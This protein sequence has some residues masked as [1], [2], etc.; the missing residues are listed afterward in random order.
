MNHQD[1][2]IIYTM[3][4]LL[5]PRTCLKRSSG[6]I[7]R[8]I[9]SYRQ[10]ASKSG[11]EKASDDKDDKK[12]DKK[13]VDKKESSLASQ[14][15]HHDLENFSPDKSS[16]VSA[17][18]GGLPGT[19]PGLLKYINHPKVMYDP[20]KNREETSY[21]FHAPKNP[22][23]RYREKMKERARGKSKLR[24]L[25]PSL[26]AASVFLWGV[27]TY[28]YFTREKDKT[29]D[30]DNALLKPS[31][32]LPYVVSF[33]YKIDDDHYL[34]ELTRK[35][36]ARKLLHTSHLFNGSRIWSIE[37]AK[38]DI[39]IVRNYTPLPLFVA[40]VDPI[41]H[42]PHL[43]LV[44]T[45]EQE[46]RFILIVKRYPD[47]E[48]SRW[49]TGMK[50]LDE[51][52]VRGPV[53][54]FKFRPHPLDRYPVRPQMANTLEKTLPDHIYPENVPKP[55]NYAFFCAGTG[56][57][58][59]LQVLYSPNPPKGFIDAYVS[60]HKQADLLK[61]IRTLNFFTEKCGRTRF[62]YF[63]GEDG[64]HI[65]AKDIRKP[66]LPNFTGT[67]DLQVSEE[68]Y[69]YKLMQQK[70]EEVRKQM[71][72]KENQ[73][74]AQAAM[75]KLS[76]IIPTATKESPEDIPKIDFSKLKP[77]NA[78]QQ[79]KFFKKGNDDPIPS[80][81]FVCGPDGYVSFVSGKPDLNNTET[82][83]KGP[84]G[85]LLKEKGWTDANVKRLTGM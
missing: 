26:I 5:V 33:K 83:D 75:E 58:P 30:T 51:V 56:V 31:K 47:G 69:R 70:K 18:N 78:F 62:H 32:F 54:E 65:Q 3:W 43:R 79:F 7:P 38:P 60:L 48:F 77:K 17:V 37:I 71:E 27:Y 67:K 85:G 82:I 4:K 55:E 36:R 80:F 66:T 63:I 11:D 84:V 42:E 25:L 34:I 21:E 29:R 24:K 1:P 20:S 2:S 59:L 16:K 74:T 13:L 72:G 23:E 9:L 50:L 39:N 8:G 15:L 73:T 64:Q 44:S 53:Q 81:A 28:D 35:N 49:L 12:D 10:F 19:D 57:M 45:A 76:G 14:K 22:K 61:E 52:Q 40:G 46:G 68:V 41:T 6:L